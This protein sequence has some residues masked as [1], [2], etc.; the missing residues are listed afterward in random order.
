M[1]W[2][3]FWNNLCELIINKYACMSVCGAVKLKSS[4]EHWLVAFWYYDAKPV[5]EKISHFNENY[6]DRR[7]GN[8]V[9]RGVDTRNL[10][11]Y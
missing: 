4:M 7:D 8:D 2:G 5:K 9:A 1:V 10:K 6:Y 11:I 3:E